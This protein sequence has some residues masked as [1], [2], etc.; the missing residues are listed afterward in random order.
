MVHNSTANC[1]EETMRDL[2]KKKWD[3][4]YKIKKERGSFNKYA[5]EHIVVFIA[6]NFYRAPDR[7]AIRILEIGCGS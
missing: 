6:K 2:N 4:I 3:E 7:A 5:T 1:L